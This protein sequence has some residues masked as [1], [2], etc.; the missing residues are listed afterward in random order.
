MNP[1]VNV[2][3]WLSG[4]VTTTSA[5]PVEPAGVV[6]GIDVEVTAPT[7]VAAAPP[8]VTVAPLTKSVPLTVTL[9]APAVGPLVGDSDETVGGGATYVNA[10][11]TVVL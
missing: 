11:L 2:L 8:N 6:T 5:A 10:P 7:V 4:F 3:L 1:P 9:V